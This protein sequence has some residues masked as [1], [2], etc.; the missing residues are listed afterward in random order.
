VNALSNSRRAKASSAHVDGASAGAPGVLLAANGLR[1]RLTTP[2]T[3]L[4]TTPTT[5]GTG[6]GVDATDVSTGDDWIEVIRSDVV[7]DGSV[8]PAASLVSMVSVAALCVA[9]V[10]TVASCPASTVADAGAGPFVLMGRAAAG[11]GFFCVVGLLAGPSVVPV[12]DGVAVL[13]GWAVVAVDSGSSSVPPPIPTATPA[14]AERTAPCFVFEP[15]VEV[16]D[17]GVVPDEPA[18][19]LVAPAAF[20]AWEPVLVRSEC[21]ECEKPAVCRGSSASAGEPT[22]LSRA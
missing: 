14:G 1:T 9:G 19:L 8:E 22:D 13:L 18:S 12:A 11:S 3:N 16:L 20:W 6:F 5:L 4:F 7:L 2:V 10:G 17:A 15:V 21:Q